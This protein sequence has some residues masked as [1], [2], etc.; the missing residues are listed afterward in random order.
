MLTFVPTRYLYTT[1][2]GRLGLL[3]NLFGA[4][5]A[6][7]LLAILWLWHA[8]PLWLVVGSLSFPAYYMAVS[9]LVSIRRWAREGK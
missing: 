9:W 5:W 8:V 3:T 1:P 7:S 6:L 4:A 2:G